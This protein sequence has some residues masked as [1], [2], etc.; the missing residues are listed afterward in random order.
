L[1][2]RSN[3]VFRSLLSEDGSLSTDFRREAEKIFNETV[4][5]TVAF[6]LKQLPL[7]EQNLALDILRNAGF[8]ELADLQARNGTDWDKTMG[9]MFPGHAGF[10]SAQDDR[11][12]PQRVEDDSNEMKIK[13]NAIV[14]QLTNDGLSPNEIRH[15]ISAL[16]TATTPT[17]KQ[18]IAKEIAQESYNAAARSI[19]KDI[20]AENNVQRK[21]A[22]EKWN[23]SMP[24]KVVN[25][26]KR[27]SR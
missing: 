27:T 9:N 13:L 4:L 8:P 1:A 11:T 23:K 22:Q 25:Y 5:K 6:I 3:R 24:N 15:Y 17:A 7:R 20:L 10:P 18:T 21:R 2:F 26:I 16:R 12:H 14:Q 19:A